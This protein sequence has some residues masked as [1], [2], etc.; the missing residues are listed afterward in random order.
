M[1]A[2]PGCIEHH[3]KLARILHEAR[4]RHRSLAV[5]WLDLANAYGSVHHS[6]IQFSL[7]HYHVP[8]KFCSLVEN[9][10]DGISGKILN[11]KWSTPEFPFQTGV[12]QGD[13]L[14][15]AIFNT[16]IN[17]LV[18]TLKSR[19]DLGYKLSNSNY[20]I[21]TLQYADDTCLVANCPAACQELLNIT[22][23]WLKWADMKAKVPKCH[24]M[25]L[26]GS[27]GCAVDPKLFL[28]GQ[29]LPFIANKTIKFLGLP[30]QIPNNLSQA[31]QDV[32]KKLSFLLQA[33][34]IC[35]VTRK[36]K[37]QLYKLGIC[38]RLNWL[39]TIFSF[40]ISWIERQLQ[41]SATN[42]LKKWSGLAISANP[43]VL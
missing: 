7:K 8:N 13:P 6:L 33:V 43:G 23:E 40:P 11:D 25:S 30:V 28:S 4:R 32:K 34:D 1:P 27:T 38:P 17:T 15:V 5:A 16:V 37:L 35:P 20:H 19:L 39:F 24:S 3:S 2:T 9:F 36:Q 26:Q 22:D 10:Y 42:F 21:N 31:K 14:S 41:T 18:D 12:Y 29:S